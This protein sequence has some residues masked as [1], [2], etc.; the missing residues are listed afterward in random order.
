MSMMGNLSLF[1]KYGEGVTEGVHRHFSQVY[2]IRR[3]EVLAGLDKDSARKLTVQ[4][5]HKF[6][7]TIYLIGLRKLRARH[8]YQAMTAE[9]GIF[10][11]GN[12]KIVYKDYVF[13]YMYRGTAIYMW[14]MY[15]DVEKPIESEYDQT[16]STKNQRKVIKQSIQEFREAVIKL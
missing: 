1:D 3:E 6:P 10:E 7:S 9:N 5:I 11:K 2:G 4:F 8:M 13:V 15:E 14:H 16:A 12:H